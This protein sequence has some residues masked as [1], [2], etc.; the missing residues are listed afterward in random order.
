MISFIW[1]VESFLLFCFFASPLE[2]QRKGHS[3]APLP[4][5]ISICVLPEDTRD[6]TW[7]SKNNVRV[8]MGPVR[9]AKSSPDYAVYSYYDL[10]VKSGKK[11]KM[12]TCRYRLK[13]E[14]DFIQQRKWHLPWG[15]TLLGK[16]A[17]GTY[18]VADP[19]GTWRDLEDRIDFYEIKNKEG[20]ILRKRSF[21]V[22]RK[23]VGLLDAVVSPDGKRILWGFTYEKTLPSKETVA[24]NTFWVSQIMGENLRPVGSFETKDIEHPKYLQ[25]A[26]SNTQIGF[27]LNNTV[28]LAPIK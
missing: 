1:Q 15:A 3:P 25:W 7:I 2:A 6:F 11:S 5:A 27:A 8:A 28:W 19:M 12:K 9:I 21:R 24:V 10:N 23:D 20:G 16:S 26:S 13:Y 22:P 4:G 17:K 14:S 18:I